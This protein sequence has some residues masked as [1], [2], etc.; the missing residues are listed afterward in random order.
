MNISP[1]PNRN[2][3]IPANIDKYDNLKDIYGKT[4]INQYD[5]IK[6][7]LE[8]EL[9][10][11]P[12]EQEKDKILEDIKRFS[13][14]IPNIIINRNRIQNNIHTLE[15]KKQSITEIL[16]QYIKIEE[17]YRKMY[18]KNDSTYNNK[19]ISPYYVTK[20]DA[21]KKLIFAVDENDNQLVEDV[22]KN[23]QKTNFLMKP[24]YI[25][26]L[27]EILSDIEKEIVVETQT[28]EKENEI[29]T[30]YRKIVKDSVDE[31]FTNN[32]LCPVCLTESV[33]MFTIP[34]GHTFCND[35]SGKMTN[36]CFYCNQQ[37]T[38]KSRL[39]IS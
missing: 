32:I 24:I 12:K 37:V 18:M 33:T 15:S 9:K 26:N 31:K 35:C 17:S 30:T 13:N 2:A 21:S 14:S 11:R 34:C 28:L 7:E 10:T 6:K 8:L 5:T 1:T 3:P 19:L 27:C 36:K 4:V 23:L 25:E 39:F 29:I 16:D 22:Y 38:K 20:D